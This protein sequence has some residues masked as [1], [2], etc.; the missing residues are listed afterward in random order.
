MIEMRINDWFCVFRC[1]FT[2]IIPQQFNYRDAGGTFNLKVVSLHIIADKSSWHRQKLKHIL[3]RDVSFQDK[4]KNQ[5]SWINWNKVNVMEMSLSCVVVVDV[6]IVDVII[7]TEF[8][9]PL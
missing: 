9:P 6:V 4:I 3:K 7:W 2:Q 8:I 1:I 5:A